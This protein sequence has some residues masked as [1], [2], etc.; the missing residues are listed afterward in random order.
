MAVSDT[1]LR[2][3]YL[4]KILLERTD[5]ENIMSSEDLVS[6]LRSY[7]MECER[8]SVYSDIGTLTEYGLDIVRVTGRAITSAPGILNCRRS[9]CW[10][11]QSRRPSSSRPKNP[12]S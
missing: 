6:A 10:W 3:L 12:V 1:K 7:G 8:K 5:E 11:T 2:M 4:M 9:S